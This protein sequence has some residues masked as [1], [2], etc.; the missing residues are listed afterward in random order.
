MSAELE[1]LL[2]EAKVIRGALRQRGQ[3]HLDPL[4]A[5]TSAKRYWNDPVGF[6]REILG[7]DQPDRQLARYQADVLEGLAASPTARVAM[8]SPRGCGKTVTGAVAVLWFAFTR[9]PEDWRVI[10]TA[11]VGRQLDYLWQELHNAASRARWDLIGRTVP[12]SRDELMRRSISLAGGFANSVSVSNPSAIEGVHGKHCLIIY[13][14]A[15]AIDEP[16]WDSLWG[17]FL[18]VAEEK[19]ALAISIPGPPSGTYYDICRGVVPGWQVRAVTLEEAVQEGRMDPEEVDRLRAIY[20]VDSP[21]YR[22]HV[23]GEFA[24]LEDGLIPFPWV[25][26]AFDLWAER[27][28]DGVEYDGIDAL[29][30][31]V[32]DGGP[33]ASIAAVRVGLDIT[34]VLDWS[35]Q[36]AY[37][38]MALAEQAFAWQQ[39]HG[40][41]PTTVDADGLGTGV[42]SRLIELGVEV[43][44]FRGGEGTDIRDEGGLLVFGNKRA[45][46]WWRLR[47]LLEPQQYKPGEG[48][49]LPPSPELL[50][51]L[52]SMEWRET[53]TG[54]IL[55]VRK[56][57]LKTSLGRSPDR[58][59]AVV[60]AYWNESV[61]AV[62][63]PDQPEERPGQM[64]GMTPS[65][66]QRGMRYRK[67]Q[68]GW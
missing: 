60:L 24:L 15:Y 17:T 2:L 22:S 30:L 51:D 38:T 55:M 54:R 68:W 33:D 43:L 5:T 62:L 67:R 66:R 29:G 10:T 64:Q 14:E 25:E 40:G 7:F 58:G 34:E 50:A 42:A 53:P 9:T 65:E 37:E 52:T 12:R 48:P 19:L 44:P 27:Y 11:G 45:A 63:P 39:G 18:H 61:A 35:R 59:D 6:A 49:A 28:G 47:D 56:E 20:G 57:K 21:V 4:G 3:G 31:D 8:R 41:V 46:A 26:R 32:S 1:A 36:D 23:L 13:D 16:V